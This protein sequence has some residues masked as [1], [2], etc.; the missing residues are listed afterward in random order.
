MNCEYITPHNTCG[1]I[2]KEDHRYSCDVLI[3]K[4]ECP[5][6]KMRERVYIAGPMRGK[7]DFNRKAFM[8]AERVLRNLGHDVVNPA[9]F[10]DAYGTPD[11]IAA[12]KG[13]LHAVMQGELRELA[14]CDTIYL[15]RGWES[16]AGARGEL[17][18]AIQLE[19]P[20]I[21]QRITK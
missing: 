20:I 2:D 16:S 17:A 6:N 10:G 19:L 14:K 18:L 3:A 4:K 15:L 5:L 12:D 13:L 9:T 1:L 7:P 21:Q 8:E 11:E